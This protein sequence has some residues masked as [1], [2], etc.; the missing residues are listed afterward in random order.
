MIFLHEHL[1]AFELDE[2]RPLGDPTRFLGA[3]AD[4]V[5]PL[6]GRGRLAGR[7]PCPGRAARDAAAAADPADDGAGRASPPPARARRGLRDATRSSCIANGCVDFG[8]QVALALRLVRTSA[9]ARA[10]IQARFRYV[11]VDEFQDTNRAQSRAGRR[12]SPSRTGT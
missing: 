7:V 6:Q 12:S 1:F 3:L 10:E 9:A 2:Y 5:Q 11:L 8:D 4:A